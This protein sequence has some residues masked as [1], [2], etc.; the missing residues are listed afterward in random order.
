V[1]EGGREGGREP[2]IT[3]AHPTTASDKCHWN[4]YNNNRRATPDTL[5]YSPCRGSSNDT[6][7]YFPTELHPEIP[8][9]YE[10]TGTGS[11]ERHAQQIHAW[12][13]WSQFVLRERE[14]ETERERRTGV[15]AI[16][17]R[18]D[19]RVSAKKVHLGQVTR[20]QRVD[21]ELQRAVIAYI[22]TA[23]ILKTSG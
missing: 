10:H 19:E 20:Q 13:L 14:R 16:A 18:N 3:T 11:R 22:Y 12:V 2:C 9:L 1:R 4:N 15:E 23:H 8:V 7:T 5:T 21:K 17:Q 6:L